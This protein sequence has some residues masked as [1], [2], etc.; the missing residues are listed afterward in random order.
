MSE[1]KILCPSCGFSKNL[2]GHAVPPEGTR[3]V[4][5]KCRH[6]FFLSLNPVPHEKEDSQVIAEP[7]VR[8]EGALRISVGFKSYTAT[9]NRFVGKG[10]VRVNADTIE[11]FARRRRLFAF[12][13]RTE[14]FSLSSIRNVIRS[15][16]TISFFLPL[17]RGCWRAFLVCHDEAAAERLEARLPR[18]IDPSYSTLRAA[19]MELKE[20]VEQLPGNT[21]AAWTIL[22]LNSLIY[23]AIAFSG[24]SWT[25]LDVGQLRAVGGNFSPLT[26]GGEWWRMITSTFLHGGLLHLVPNMFALYIFGRLTER[27]YGTGGFLGIYILSGLAGAAGTLVASP[28]AVSVGASGAIFGV[29]GAVVAFLATDRQLLTQGA[30]QQLLT[31]LVVYATYTL[32]G[33]F[34]KSGID[35][36]AHIGGLMAGLVLGWMTGVPP[37]LRGEKAGWITGAVASGIALVLVG[38]GIAVAMAPRPGPEYRTLEKMIELTREMDA[39][40]KILAEE[41]KKLT[42]KGSA[43][44]KAEAEAYAHLVVRTYQEFDDKLGAL[45]P[46]KQELKD[47]QALL[48][49]YI[50]LKKEGG[51]LLARGIEVENEILIKEAKEKIVEANKMAGDIVKPVKWYR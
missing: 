35:N 29:I 4:C 23:L 12:R 24:K 49:K 39:R 1:Y 42:A 45:A 16:K 26:I 5:P 9:D 18:L 32:I 15:G 19:R 3:A 27:I 33:G 41:G 20:R 44:T 37:R 36:A 25:T 51:M 34:R 17:K 13:R 21:P 31:V 46:T 48:D 40:E 7:P 11:I 47:R 30:R 2:P 38:T 6:K 50:D 14:T 43:A 8:Q 10:V 22:A 28:D